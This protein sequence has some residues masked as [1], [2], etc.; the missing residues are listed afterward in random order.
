MIARYVA[1]GLVACSAWLAALAQESLADLVDEANASWMLGKWEAEIDSGKVTLEF[2]WDL[3]KH[4]VV[5]H[6]K[7]PDLEFKGY[8]AREPGS[9][10]EVNYYGF[11]NRGSVTKGAW[12]L[13]GD[14]L[15]LKVETRSATRTTKMGV[16]FAGNATDGLVLRLHG[17]DTFGNLVTPARAELKLKKVK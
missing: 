17:L 12:T 4:V 5:L 8:T 11:D 16:V 1:I 14:E 15:V 7:T 9:M 3:D 2:S 10:N 13:E 6:G